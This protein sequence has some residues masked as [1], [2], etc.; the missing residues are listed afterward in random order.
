MGPVQARHDVLLVRGEVVIVRVCE[1]LMTLVPLVTYQVITMVNT[2]AHSL[3]N[4]VV[5]SLL[6]RK[7]LHR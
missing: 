4:L 2:D 7:F 3:G 6:V 1:V 5:I